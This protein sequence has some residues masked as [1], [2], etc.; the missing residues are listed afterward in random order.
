M[1]IVAGFDVHRA[2]I[3]FDALDTETGEVT[4]GRVDSTPAAVA[5]SAGRFIGREIHVAVEAWA[6]TYACPASGLMTSESRDLWKDRNSLSQPGCFYITDP[7]FGTFRGTSPSSRQ[8]ST[9]APRAR[10]GSGCR[11]GPTAAAVVCSQACSTPVR[12]LA[13]ASSGP[14]YQN[15]QVS[16]RSPSAHPPRNGSSRKLRRIGS[17]SAL[18]TRVHRGL[19][20][21]P[22]VVTCQR[23]RPWRSSSEPRRPAVTRRPSRSYT[24]TLAPVRTVL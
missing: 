21:G 8:S 9:V 11:R 18:K 3:T 2:Q 16:S 15:D 23:A 24:R 10:S 1:A 6:A 14:A 12:A 17:A 19:Q 4:R 13:G 20:D 7:A 22:E 5:R